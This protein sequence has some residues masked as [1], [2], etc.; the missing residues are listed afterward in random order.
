MAKKV[1]LVKDAKIM[2][3]KFLQY[4]EQE[5]LLKSGE[6]VLLAV[7]GGKDSMVMVDLFMK[8]NLSF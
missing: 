1:P 7:S 6:K 3:Q 5:H 4:I 2:I 8:A